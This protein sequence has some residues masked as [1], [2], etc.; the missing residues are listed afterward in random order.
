[1]RTTGPNYT[2]K[3]MGNA[4]ALFGIPC[5][6]RLDKQV[7]VLVVQVAENELLEHG[8]VA[9]EAVDSA[10]IVDAMSNHLVDLRIVQHAVFRLPFGLPSLT[11]MQA[12]HAS[13]GI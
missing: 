8:G 4:K 6:N 1:M 10:T 9:S 12:S 13:H 7:V 11:I 5:F 2:F 3:R